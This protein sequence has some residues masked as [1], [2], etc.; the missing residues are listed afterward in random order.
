MESALLASAPV[1]E[2]QTWAALSIK[3]AVFSTNDI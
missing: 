3:A 2:P 1:A